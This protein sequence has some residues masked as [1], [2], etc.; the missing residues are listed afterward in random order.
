L[1]GPA[2]IEHWPE[3]F[4]LGEREL[5]SFVGAG[6]KT[7]LMLGLGGDLAD[8]GR[9]VVITTT[10]KMGA[11]QIQPPVVGSVAN[12]EANFG[13]RPGPMF[14]VRR[15]V[16]SKVTGPSPVE[17]NELFRDSSVEYILVEADGAHGR[18]LKVPADFEPVIPTASTTVVPVVGIDAI[19]SSIASACHRPERVAELLERPVTHHLEPADVAKVITSARGG[20]KDVPA[21]AKVVVAVTKVGSSDMDTARQLSILI[22]KDPDIDRVVVVPRF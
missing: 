14:V 7:T 5:V 2:L 12:V 17:I 15:D 16:D 18:S 3:R 11:E 4:G 1:A 9:R 6:G 21:A 8:A 10:T 22:T 19:G 20:M 13:R